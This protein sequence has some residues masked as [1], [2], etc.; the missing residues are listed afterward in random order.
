MT[1]QQTEKSSVGKFIGIGCGC[2]TLLAVLGLAG[3]L[4]FVNTVIKGPAP[5]GDSL[6]AVQKNAAAIEALGEPIKPGFFPTGSVNVNNDSGDVDFKIGVSGPKGAGTI[7]VKGT[8]SGGV[9]TYDVWELKV[10]GQPDPIPL[11]K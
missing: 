5:Y 7:T 2:A 9:W 10:D 8:R 3:C 4:F 11:S 1:V 6:A